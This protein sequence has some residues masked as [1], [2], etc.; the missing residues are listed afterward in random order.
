MLADC[1]AAHSPH[2]CYVT[3]KFFPRSVCPFPAYSFQGRLVGVGKQQCVT[4]E[5]WASVVAPQAMLLLA[6]YK[7]AT[8]MSPN[9]QAS[10]LQTNFQSELRSIN[11][12]VCIQS[13]RS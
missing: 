2:H 5:V 4:P 13:F 11:A 6:L 3:H 7:M 9:A 8:R 10:R 1:S 12:S